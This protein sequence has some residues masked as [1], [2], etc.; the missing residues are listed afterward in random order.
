MPEPDMP[1]MLAVQRQKSNAR[2]VEEGEAIALLLAQCSGRL[3]D[4]GRRMRQQHNT[5]TTAPY[6]NAVVWIV[7]GEQPLAWTG[8]A[9]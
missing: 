6:S 5:T 2:K 4:M 3:V 8:S 7:A 1:Y 9:I